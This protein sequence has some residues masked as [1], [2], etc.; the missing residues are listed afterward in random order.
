MQ[1]WKSTHEE[2]VRHRREIRGQYGQRSFFALLVLCGISLELGN[3]STLVPENALVL[4][5]MLLTLGYYLTGVTARGALLS[6]KNQWGNQMVCGLVSASALFMG[7]VVGMLVSAV[8][9]S[10]ELVPLL[11]LC[12][13]VFAVLLAWGC[14]LWARAVEQRRH[15]PELPEQTALY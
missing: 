2:E 10:L 3:W 7:F 15:T 1:E 8:L 11:M 5:S 4:G 6:P 14:A 13:G 9:E 12:I